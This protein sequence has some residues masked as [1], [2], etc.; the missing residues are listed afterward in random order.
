M[1]K[2]TL[3]E[4]AYIVIAITVAMMVITAVTSPAFK[5]KTKNLVD[6]S[7]P[8]HEQQEYY[9]DKAFREHLESVD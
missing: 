6:Q 5:E 3:S 7:I 4:M 2:D 8:L 9:N 1:D